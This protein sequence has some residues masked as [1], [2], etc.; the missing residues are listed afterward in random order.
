MGRT[1]V[2]GFIGDVRLVVRRALRPSDREFDEHIADAV[3][4]LDST[5]VVLVALVGDALDTEFAAKQRAKLSIP[6]L[7]KKPHAVLAPSIRPEVLL[8]RR[9]VG[10]ARIRV[11][12][13]DA[14]HDACDFLEVASSL[15]PELHAALAS[16]KE[17]VS[18]GDGTIG[19]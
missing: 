11:F 18:G 2:Q 9:W 16:G 7:F 5:R 13:P 4:G 8:S 3:A 1:L 19:R 15:R 14:F 10:E 12:G 17:Q 6:G